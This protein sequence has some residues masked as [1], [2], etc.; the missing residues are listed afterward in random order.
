MKFYAFSGPRSLDC[1]EEWFVESYLMNLVSS[2]LGWSVGDASGVDALVRQI[3]ERVNLP[4][5]L[6]WTK[7]YESW[8]LAKRSKSMVDFVNSQGG[9]LIAF[10]NCPCPEACYPS[11][12]VIGAGS[13]TWLTIAYAVYRKVPVQVVA[14]GKFQSPF[15]FWLTAKQLSLF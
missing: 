9:Q 4:I 15:P 13:G 11:A 1:E 2:S 10:P 6:F 5:T 12:S 3:A 7:G 8:Q 14:I